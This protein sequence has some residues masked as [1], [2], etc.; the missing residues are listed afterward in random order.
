MKIGLI[1]DIHEHTQELRDVIS[2]LNRHD[3]DRTLHLGDIAS[4]GA[5][6]DQTCSVLTELRVDGVWGNHELG[7]VDLAEDQEAAR[8]GRY[9]EQTLSYLAELKPTILLRDDTDPVLRRGVLLCHAGPWIDPFDAMAMWTSGPDQLLQPN[10][11]ADSLKDT[12]VGLAFMGHHH[13]WRAFSDGLDTGW[14]GESPLT[15]EQHRRLLVVVNPVSKRSA[16]ILDTLRGVI[17]PITAPGEPS[18]A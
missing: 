12:N 18:D 13:C 8:S 1:A 11:I 10:R 6:L 2:E 7:L 15:V 16:L 3:V 9:S 17:E 14:R 4:H 5:T